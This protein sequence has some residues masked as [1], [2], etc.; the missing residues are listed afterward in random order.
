[1]TFHGTNRL[2]HTTRKRTPSYNTNNTNNNNNNNSINNNLINNNHTITMS[3]INTTPIT[4]TTSSSHPV[5]RGSHTHSGYEQIIEGIPASH[6]HTFVENTSSGNTLINFKPVNITFNKTKSTTNDIIDFNITSPTQHLSSSSCSSLKQTQSEYNDDYHSPKPPEI[7]TSNNVITIP[8][9]KNKNKSKEG[10]N[11][12]TTPSILTTK[13]NTQNIIHKKKHK[14]K[15]KSS[16]KRSRHR[17][18]HRS[19]NINHYH[20]IDTNNEIWELCKWCVFCLAALGSCIV[21]ITYLLQITGSTDNNHHSGGSRNFPHHIPFHDNDDNTQNIFIRQRPVGQHMTSSKHRIP[22]KKMT[23][24]NTYNDNNH[25]PLIDPNTYNKE[26]SL[27]RT[28]KNQIENPMQY[29]I[30]RND[31]FSI[32]NDILFLVFKS[33]IDDDDDD[34]DSYVD[35]R[36]MILNTWGKKYQGKYNINI[37][38]VNTKSNK[39]A[40]D[41]DGNLYSDVIEAPFDEESAMCLLWAIDEYTDGFKW[42]FK[43]DDITFV[44]IENLVD[45]LNRIELESSLL[46]QDH[47]KNDNDVMI[48]IEHHYYWWLGNRLQQK[49]DDDTTIFT[50]GQAGYLLNRAILDLIVDDIRNYDE[51]NGISINDKNRKYDKYMMCKQQNINIEQED[52]CIG[53][54]MNT[55]YNIQSSSTLDNEN[56]EK[57]NVW[58]PM[59]LFGFGGIYKLS[60]D[61]YNKYKMNIGEYEGDNIII[62]HIS[63]TPI[64]FHYIKPKW[65]MAYYQLLYLHTN[66]RNIDT[67]SSF[68]GNKQSDDDKYKTLNYYARTVKQYSLTNHMTNNIQNEINSIITDLKYNLVK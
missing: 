45:Y 35:G 25:L 42:I 33:N 61:W 3:N 55:K 49:P 18:F 44:M 50:S 23:N 58:D 46:T 53:Y 65:M 40:N 34:D 43:V 47:N 13:S 52:L 4:I 26:I 30:V 29:P 12:S 16:S 38:F 57:F 11:V 27:R 10:D 19:H 1:M 67:I 7:V 21:F 2:I 8:Q 28:Q 17:K 9:K 63:K 62:N 20:N 68:I 32:L 64:T 5:Y 15:S 41:D 31:K 66:S 60:S 54:L 36:E 22:I 56:N 39:F 51:I 6:S 48:D 24:S 37:K 14:S 59:T